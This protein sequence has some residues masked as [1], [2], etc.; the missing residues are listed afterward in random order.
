MAA[1]KASKAVLL[2][3][4]LLA[5]V[6]VL[7]LVASRKHWMASPRA[8]H[9]APPA[10]LRHAAV[11]PAVDKDMLDAAV[12]QAVEQLAGEGALAVA[13]EA[14]TA[15]QA[16]QAKAQDAE[17]TETE[18][19][20]LSPLYVI[21]PTHLVP[22]QLPQLTRLAQTLLLVPGAYWLLV[23]DADRTSEPVAALLRRFGERGLR[24]EHLAERMPSEFRNLERGKPKG[25]AQRNRA[26]R[27]LRANATDGVLYFADDD[28]TYDVQ[29]F[30]EI[31]T[32]QRVSMFPVGLVT[33]L[34]VSSP[35]VIG[36]ELVGF[37][38]GWIA[39][40]KFPV[41]MAGFAVSVRFLLE[42]P[43]GR[44]PFRA[45]YEEDGFL[46]SLAPLEPGDVELKA[47]NCSRI[48]VWHTRSINPEPAAPVDMDTYNGT[49]V[50][51]LR[52]Q[53]V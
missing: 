18:A 17:A 34:G 14:A 53:L 6:I 15:Q 1:S 19:E 40:R 11:H 16:A 45:G 5:V 42:R 41:D 48:L 43:D 3:W 49:N 32:T 31:R 28:N 12:R 33:N 20:E 22:C 27:W 9:R 4:V 21:T 52:D 35:L 46:R 47:A 26:L 37:Y 8:G 51:I 24:Y 38:D 30:E 7:L 50:P 25:V 23:E 2:R 29:L 13:L 39:G 44:M 36:G 10:V